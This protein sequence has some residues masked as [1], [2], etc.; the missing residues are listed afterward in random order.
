MKSAEVGREKNPNQNKKNLC[1]C[2]CVV[3]GRGKAEGTRKRPA[4]DKCAG[5]ESY[6][7]VTIELVVKVMLHETICKD[8]S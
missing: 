8:D 4:W 3:E 6:G 7:R 2:V 1:V 5:W